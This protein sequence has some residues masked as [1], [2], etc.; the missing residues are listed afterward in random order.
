[1]TVLRIRTIAL[2]TVTVGIALWL[3]LEARV[4]SPLP[5]V[6]PG[7]SPVYDLRPSLGSWST[8]Y[9]VGQSIPLFLTLSNDPQ[10]PTPM[11]YSYVPQTLEIIVS[12]QKGLL[13]RCGRSLR[14]TLLVLRCRPRKRDCE[15]IARLYEF[16]YP[17]TYSVEV[18]R[19]Y[20]TVNGHRDVMPPSNPITITL[21]T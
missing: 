10:K 7:G 20:V 15:R 13:I 4:V 19:A 12:D 5:P 18:T 16:S 9:A 1:M 11:T 2:A 21:N 8:N 14:H 17:G 6:P 3:I